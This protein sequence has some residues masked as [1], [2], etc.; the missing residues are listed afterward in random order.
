MRKQ[1]K[2]PLSFLVHDIL[3]VSV[4]KPLPF[5]CLAVNR[6]INSCK[7]KLLWGFME[8]NL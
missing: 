4:Q 7:T 3:L 8:S 2:F 6:V 1:E 5:K